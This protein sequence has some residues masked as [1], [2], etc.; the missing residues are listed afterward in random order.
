MKRSR[1]GRWLHDSRE[2]DKNGS[3]YVLPLLLFKVQV[4]VQVLAVGILTKDHT[5]IVL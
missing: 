3:T 2:N 1:A 4:K 5:C